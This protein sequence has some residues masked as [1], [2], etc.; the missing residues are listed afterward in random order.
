[1]MHG[2]DRCSNA[3]SIRAPSA[4]D[5]HR[6][7]PGTPRLD[8]PRRPASPP[9]RHATHDSRPPPARNL[10]TAL[11]L[12]RTLIASSFAVSSFVSTLFQSSAH[13]G[14][15]SVLEQKLLCTSHAQKPITTT[16]PM[17]CVAGTALPGRK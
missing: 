6:S 17:P 8:M 2:P 1:M 4:H 16:G 7:S 3:R 11:P 12:L 9:A 10:R 15:H 14:E 13:E 5:L